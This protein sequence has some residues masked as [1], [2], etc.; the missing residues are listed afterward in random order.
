MHDRK[1]HLLEERIPPVEKKIPPMAGKVGRAKSQK[2]VQTATQLTQLTIFQQMQPL[3]P[4]S[5]GQN[6]PDQAYY[7][8]QNAY[9]DSWLYRYRCFSEDTWVTTETGRKNMSELKIGDF[10]MTANSK[11]VRRGI[12][13][14]TVF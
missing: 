2:P 12:R 9:M 10:V 7:G 11:E 6:A 4:Q 8:A 1:I 13:D 3:P 5:F 14:V